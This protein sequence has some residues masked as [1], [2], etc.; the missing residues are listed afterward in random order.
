MLDYDENGKIVNKTPRPRK[1]SP[2]SIRDTPTHP[3]KW[4]VYYNE[5][6]EAKGFERFSSEEEAIAFIERRMAAR[7]YAASIDN[8]SLVCGVELRLTPVVQIKKVAVVRE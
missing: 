8:Y 5:D 4:F 3:H 1:A 7:T 6:V 2:Q